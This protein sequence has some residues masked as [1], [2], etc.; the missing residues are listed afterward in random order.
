MSQ[1]SNQVAEELRK[2][3]S[4]IFLEDLADERLGFVTITR[5]EITE[6]LRFARVYYSVL[7]GEAEKESTREAV[8][9]QAPYLRRLAVERI[10]MKYAMEF[11]FELDRSIDEGF[12][13]DEIFKKLKKKGNP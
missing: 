8:E 7:G 12:R 4:Q 13:I 10:N 3:I 2:I 6:D 5:V 11:K 1:R 9:E